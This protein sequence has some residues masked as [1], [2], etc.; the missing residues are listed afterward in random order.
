VQIL[1]TDDRG[2]TFRQVDESELTKRVDVSENDDQKLVATEY[3]L[4]GC[5]GAAHTTGV[6]QGDGSFCE[7]HV[8]RSVHLT[9]KRYPEFAGAIAASLV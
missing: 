8:H 4:T 6:A 1:I 3:C 2:A 5:G 7:R 9:I